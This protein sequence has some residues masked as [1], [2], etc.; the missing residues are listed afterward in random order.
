MQSAYNGINNSRLKIVW[1][2]SIVCGN[3]WDVEMLKT[4]ELECA[5]EARSIVAILIIIFSQTNIPYIS[6]GRNSHDSSLSPLIRIKQESVILKMKLVEPNPGCTDFAGR[7][8]CELLF[9]L[10]C[11]HGNKR[12]SA[13]LVKI[14]LLH[15]CMKFIVILWRE[16][17]ACP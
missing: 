13:E 3:Q 6:G 16:W 1:F 12:Q 2:L 10:Y 7:L 8:K 17:F 11:C 4:G 5:W 15:V 14:W 9:E